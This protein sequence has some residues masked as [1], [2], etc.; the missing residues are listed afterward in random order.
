MYLLSF[1][2][3]CNF[4][5]EYACYTGHILESLILIKILNFY[6]LIKDLKS[7]VFIVIAS[8]LNTPFYEGYHIS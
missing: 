6:I 4:I 5:L 1:S 3:L 7:F 8:S 2:L